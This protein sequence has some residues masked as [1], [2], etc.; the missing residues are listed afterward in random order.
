MN[1][2]KK[3]KQEDKRQD[4]LFDAL[5]EIM[6]V[7]TKTL[8]KYHVTPK[9]SFVILNSLYTRICDTIVEQRGEGLTE[10]FTKLWIANQVNKLMDCI[11]NELP[12]KENED[13][14]E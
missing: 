3:N 13:E 11:L 5:W 14:Q 2:K 9:E 4:E 6:E 10:E 1:S 8:D 12:I 7:V